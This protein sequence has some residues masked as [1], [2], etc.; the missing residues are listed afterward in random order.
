MKREQEDSGFK[1]RVIAINRV[2]KVNKGGRRFSFSALVVVGDGKGNVGIGLGKSMEV[3]DAIKKANE[4]AKKDMIPVA[5]HDTTIPFEVLGKYG[6]ARVLMRRAPA[7][8]G[9]IAGGPVRALAELAG[10]KDI[11][12]KCH[13]TANVHNVTK[14]AL[15]AFGLLANKEDTMRRRG[16]LPQTEQ[17]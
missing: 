12:T 5:I 2:T 4:R 1:D 16:F 17:R 8:T 10:I 9:V 13:G 14:A 3:P 7:G 15:A 11:V 6:S